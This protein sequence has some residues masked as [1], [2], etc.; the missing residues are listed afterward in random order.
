VETGVP[1]TGFHAQFV[2][3][4][5]AHFQRLH[6]YLNRLS[7]DSELAA[8]VAQEA[9]VKLYQRGSLPD[10]PGAWLITVAMNLF[11]NAAKSRR[12]RLELLTSARAE[13]ILADPPI[14][15]DR[16]VEAGD[17]RRRVRSALDRMSERDRTMLLL[18]AEGYGYR[19]IAAA[20]E[21]NEKSV[22]VFLARA[23]RAFRE[24]YEESSDASG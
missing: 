14:S 17:S 23:R 1:E 16:A 21:V 9:F 24:I 22:G 19:E 18:H 2:E 8:D 20:L 4:F 7:G 10:D 15:P 5:E 11:R 12:R 6:R 3:L 13:G